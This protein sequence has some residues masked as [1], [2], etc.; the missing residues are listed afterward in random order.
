MAPGTYPTGRE[1]VARSLPSTRAMTA[2][3]FSGLLVIDMTHVLNGPFA[4]TLLTDLGARVI[5]IEPPGHGDDTRG[6][7]PFHKGQSLY[8]SSI[9]RGKE[10]IVLNLKDE[11]DREIF[12]NMVRQADVV[13]ENFRPGAM[14][15]LGFAYEDLSRLNPRLIYAS[16]SGFGQTGPLSTYPAYDTI[17]QAMSGIMSLTGSPDGPPT[18][19]G[20]SLSDLIA[21]VFMFSGI[22][23]ALYAREQTGAGAQVDVAMFDSAFAFLE[24][25]GMEYLATGEAPG[26]IGNRHPS[27]APFDVF[28]SSDG[29]VI[30][31]CGNDHLFNQL[32]RTIGRPE[33]ITDKRFQGN[34]DRLENNVALK[35]E[36]EVTLK[37]EPAA[38]WLEIIHEAGVPIG[39]L[40]NVAEA[41]EHP[42]ISARNMVIEAGNL[43]MPGNPV[44]ISGYD[45]PH[46]RNG[47]PALDQHG[48]ALRREFRS[49]NPPE[50]L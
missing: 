23:S 20:T 19:V 17:I 21:G 28:E 36:L 11:A 9:N 13:A 7:G 5:K 40:L 39:P 25:G 43:R 27:I 10:S 1:Q 18:R 33:L 42:Q 35:A 24:H 4:T 3:P 6:Y 46:V 50:N 34:H 8:F 14:A 37:R 26:R 29:Q 30:I 32:C 48:A 45:D 15:R 22:V 44:K 41:A 47:A 38:Y 16:S 2:G 12:L 49:S 31:C